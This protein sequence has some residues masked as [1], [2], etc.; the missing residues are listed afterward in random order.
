MKT[1]TNK[2]PS[3]AQYFAKEFEKNGV[4]DVEESR[5]LSAKW[6]NKIASE[7][8][9]KKKYVRFTPAGPT[10]SGKTK[11][12]S[13]PTG[14]PVKGFKSI[15]E[16]AAN[17][18]APNGRRTKNIYLSHVPVDWLLKNL[19]TLNSGNK[20]SNAIRDYPDFEEWLKEHSETGIPGTAPGSY[21]FPIRMSGPAINVQT[22]IKSYGLD[23][24]RLAARKEI[25]MGVFNDVNWRMIDEFAFHGAVEVVDGNG[26]KIPLEA[27]IGYPGWEDDH[28]Y[29]ALYVH[30]LDLR[31]E[32]NKALKIKDA[33]GKDLPLYNVRY[34]SARCY[35]SGE[36]YVAQNM[37]MTSRSGKDGKLIWSKAR[38]GDE[39]G[40]AVSTTNFAKG[41]AAAVEK[42]RSSRTFKPDGSD[43]INK[44]VSLV[45]EKKKDKKQGVLGFGTPGRSKLATEGQTEY[46]IV[47]TFTYTDENGIFHEI[48]END[49]VIPVVKRSGGK[50]EKVT[51]DVDYKPGA[52]LEAFASA[53]A[54]LVEDK[55][56]QDIISN[57][58]Q[59]IAQKQADRKK[60]LANKKSSASHGLPRPQFLEDEFELQTAPDSQTYE[61]IGPAED[62]ESVE[63]SEE[64]SESSSKA[65]K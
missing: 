4:P 42:A 20:I 29:G 8:F 31:F 15:L 64:G 14:L 40:S 47:P 21:H 10:K 6:S 54:N 32:E 49:L 33:N 9:A 22:A 16:G 13:Q 45:L 38:V 51:F 50:G 30:E 55:D 48:K 36:K 35:V 7:M 19:K 60:S 41:L 18:N 17:K 25:E 39:K 61:N 43:V 5:S 44:T 34:I 57:L 65:S 28:P 24:A 11:A 3:F 59:Q 58:R 62:E 56:A 2:K 12:N 53:L 46:A 63:E 37:M 52:V 26:E 1:T 27:N 23:F